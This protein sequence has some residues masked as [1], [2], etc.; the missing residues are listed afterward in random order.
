MVRRLWGVKVCKGGTRRRCGRGG[1]ASEAGGGV[2][3][4]GV[5]E[6]RSVRIWEKEGRVT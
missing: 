3:V 4:R 2:G 1:V 5:Q 6:E